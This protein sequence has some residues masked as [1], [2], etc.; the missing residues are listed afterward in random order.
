MFRKPEAGLERAV[1]LQAPS[2]RGTRGKELCTSGKS[3]PADADKFKARGEG[4][5]RTQHDAASG[6][7]P[8]LGF[9]KAPTLGLPAPPL[10]LQALPS[11]LAVLGLRE[12]TPSSS[13][14]SVGTASASATRATWQAASCGQRWS[15][16]SNPWPSARRS[17]STRR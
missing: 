16:A 13:V 1:R 10:S 3:V 4:G 17:W 14:R 9:R 12:V 2:S 15:S 7:R 8:L 11:G 5:K 6:R